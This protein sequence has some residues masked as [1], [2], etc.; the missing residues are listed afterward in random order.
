[1]EL[2]R[3]RELGGGLGLEMEGLG[4]VVFFR[5]GQIFLQKWKFL[6]QVVLEFSTFLKNTGIE[7]VV[8]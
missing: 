4:L 3:L 5:D 2:G 1:M 8:L 7:K 6:V